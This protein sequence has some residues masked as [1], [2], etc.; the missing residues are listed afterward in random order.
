MKHREAVL[1]KL[2]SMDSNLN[3]LNMTL[4]QGD[5]QTAY[6]LTE[7]LREQIE[8]IKGYIENESIQGSELNRF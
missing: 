8:Q 3:K 2:D 4:N 1:K 5:R 7:S 6:E